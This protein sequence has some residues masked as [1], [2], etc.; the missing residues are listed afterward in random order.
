MADIEWNEFEPSLLDRARRAGRPIVL[1]LTTAWCPYSREL[2]A[3]SL[4][5]ADVVHVV[6]G[7]FLA[8]RVDAERRPDV[9]A[10]YGSGGWPTIAYLTPDGEL[11]ANDRFLGATDLA[12]R[13]RKVAEVFRT[14]RS[15]I[16]SGLQKLLSQKVD[17]EDALEHD[18][19]GMA[20]VDDIAEAIYERFDHR[21]GGFGE[22]AKFPHPE[23]VDFALV[24]AMKLGDPRMET[25]AR[26]TLDRMLA[27]AIHDSTDGGF[28]RFSSS[29]DWQTPHYEKVLEANALILRNYLEAYQIWG[30]AAY[31]RTAEGIVQWMMETLLDEET[32]ALF[33]SLDADSEYYNLDREQRR[34]RPR[35]RLDRTIYA[36]SNA[37]AVSALLKA[38]VTLERPDLRTQAM[39]ALTFVLENMFQRDVGVYHYWDG[40]YHLPGML[41]DQATVIRALVD[42][43]QHTGDADYLLPAEAVAEVAITRQRAPGGGFYDI[44]HDPAYTGSMRRRNRSILDNAM[45]A[46]SLVRLSYL[47]RRPEFHDE[48][49]RALECFARDYKEYGYYVSGFARAVDLVFYQPLMLTIV[50]DRTS[51]AAAALRSA[52]LSAYVPSRIVQ[53][54]DPK[55]DPILLSRSGY[56]VGEQ[57]TVYMSIGKTTKAVVRTPD[58]LLAKIREL[59]NERR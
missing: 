38:A 15:E 44:R 12:N 26:T 58:D 53:M 57:P 13:L 42:A 14:Q 48:A 17:D 18:A 43:S 47:S 35:P 59:E 46:E 36:N 39:R 41:A 1:V 31:R 52:A 16:Q 33:G 23:A 11:I 28:F 32:G 55:F 24:R 21:Y 20:M 49:I 10:R 2:L 30:N 37:V 6:E 22:G 34:G 50:G 3:T 7:E 56:E 54:L 27:A 40:T 25:V 9:N 45:M 19:L 5:D 8:A 51:D 29:T 4:R